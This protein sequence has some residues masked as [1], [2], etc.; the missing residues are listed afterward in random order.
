V[1]AST[2]ASRPAREMSL[3]VVG[4]ANFTELVP[5]LP[6]ALASLLEQ[7]DPDLLPAAVAAARALPAPLTAELCVRLS[8]VVDDRQQSD[9]QRVTALATIASQLPALE[10]SHWS[11]LTHAISAEHSLALRSAAAQAIVAADLSA[12]QLRELAELVP[13][14]HPL[15]LNR[16]IAAFENSTDE[17]L[18]LALL[19]SLRDAS[20]LSSLRID[21]LRQSLAKHSPVVQRG[22]DELDAML[23]VD[24]ESQRE[25][26]EELLPRVIDGDVRRGHALFHSPKAACSSCHRLGDAGGALG[27]ELTKVGEIRT[28]RD[29]LESILF[30]SLSFVQSYESTL[31]LTD[32]GKAV[33]GRIVEETST[34]YV[35]ATSA[36]ETVRVRRDDVDEIQP[37]TVSVMPAGFDK[38]LTEQELADIVAF[39]KTAK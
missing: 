21:V 1:I 8:E 6:K 3:R 29:L 19:D 2:K 36:Q 32:D 33:S 5:A 24:A 23:N 15:E 28:E 22:I 30:P 20:S 7:R 4:M 34:E 16:V 13:I 14:V 31:I 11:L 39:L 37:S 35:L 38:Q 17:Q 18:G 9:D 25:R 12:D 10:Q 26:L 27:P